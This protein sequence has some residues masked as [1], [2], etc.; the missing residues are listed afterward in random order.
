MVPDRLV[1]VGCKE[2]ITFI[3]CLLLFYSQ[4][5]VSWEKD[6]LFIE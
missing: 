1:Q 4:E 2:I 6:E 5:G 3:V